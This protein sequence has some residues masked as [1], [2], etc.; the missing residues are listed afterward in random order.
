MDRPGAFNLRLC[1]LFSQYVIGR[2]PVR[3]AFASPETWYMASLPRDAH[4]AMLLPPTGAF[5]SGTRG[6]TALVQYGT[7]SDYSHET[8]GKRAG[9]L[10]PC[11]ATSRSES[12]ARRQKYVCRR[13]S[14]L[15]L[16]HASI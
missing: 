14:Q 7:E 11:H 4:L 10:T 16:A 3:P 12:S 1:S 2:L 6:Q 8:R 15:F 9:S 13:A 5:P